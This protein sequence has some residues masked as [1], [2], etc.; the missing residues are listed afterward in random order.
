MYRV[1]QVYRKKEVPKEYRVKTQPAVPKPKRPLNLFDEQLLEVLTKITVTQTK[2][3][4]VLEE[5]DKK[6]DVAEAREY[7]RKRCI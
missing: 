6:F 1:K 7:M 2:E 5:W 4:T 3:I